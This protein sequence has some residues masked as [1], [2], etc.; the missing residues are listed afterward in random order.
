[1]INIIK[2]SYILLTKLVCSIVSLLI[3]IPI[4][5]LIIRKYLSKDPS[6]ISL[7]ESKISNYFKISKNIF[8]SKNSN[9]V[10]DKLV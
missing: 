9:D 4:S 1:M 3:L 2:Y 7:L 6:V 8:S 5:F 10:I